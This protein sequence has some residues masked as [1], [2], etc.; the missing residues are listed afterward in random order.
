MIKI[1]E[2]SP[3]YEFSINFS[4]SLIDKS[5]AGFSAKA[6]FS[7]DLDGVME[8]M[9]K[10]FGRLLHLNEK[11]VKITDVIKKIKNCSDLIE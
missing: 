3:N 8:S 10:V 5:L 9:A 2:K 11:L 7:V 4:F 6:L 1:K